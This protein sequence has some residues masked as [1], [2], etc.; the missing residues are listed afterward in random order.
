[1]FAVIGV[2][3]GDNEM[4]DECKDNHAALIMMAWSVYQE[5]S[6][7]RMLECWNAVCFLVFCNFH[8][9]LS[10]PVLTSPL[11]KHRQL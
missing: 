1:M 8:G 2:V 5:N 3:M 7:I 9:M 10:S 4:E 6:N 11:H